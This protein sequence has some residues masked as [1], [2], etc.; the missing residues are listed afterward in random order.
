MAL[1][2]KYVMNS[3]KKS[4]TE[5]ST[6]LTICEGQDDFKERYKRLISGS[7]FRGHTPEFLLRKF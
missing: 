5:V 2:S 6:N 4:V 1:S 7:G 3:E